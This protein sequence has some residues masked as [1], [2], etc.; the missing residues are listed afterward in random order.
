M[1]ATTPT[2]SVRGWTSDDDYVESFDLISADEKLVVTLL[3]YGARLLDI[4]YCGGTIM[5]GFLPTGS[6]KEIEED[7]SYAGAAIGRVCNRIRNATY[8]GIKLSASQPPHQ[9]HGGVKSWDKKVWNLS[10]RTS[11]SA[12]FTYLSPHGDQGY[13][14]SVEASVEYSLEQ[15]G[16]Y[17]SVVVKLTTTNTGNRETVTNM[18]LHP[19]FDLSGSNGTELNSV[20]RY[21][22]YAPTVSGI[23]Q[24]DDDGIPTGSVVPVASTKYSLSSKGEPLGERTFDNYFITSSSGREEEKEE[25]IKGVRDQIE[26]YDPESKL[27][28]TVRSNQD[29]FQMYTPDGGASIAIEPS[30][31]IDAPNNASNGFPSIALNAGESRSQIIEYR[32]AQ[33][34]E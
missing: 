33:V 31:H 1:M 19:Y 24:L 7:P 28:L 22:L 4:K 13:P 5:R 20:R 12:E 23:L 18:T 2:K 14:S 6:V 11:N 9:L 26:V 16:T 30:G 34:S 17:N 32:I 3:P 8:D 27:N 10:Q 25:R 29:G 15:C 21:Q